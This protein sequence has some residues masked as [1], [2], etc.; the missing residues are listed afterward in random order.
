MNCLVNSSSFFGLGFPA[1][2]GAGVPLD[3]RT[4][5]VEVRRPGPLE[6]I[7][8]PLGRMDPSMVTLLLLGFLGIFGAALFR[9][10]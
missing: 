4:A 1:G 9:R 2:A 6:R 8:E 10:R 5:G 3:P 7:S